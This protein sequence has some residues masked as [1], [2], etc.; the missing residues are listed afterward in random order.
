[1]AEGVRKAPPTAEERWP[2][3][4]AGEV[5]VERAPHVSP[6][7]GDKDAEQNMAGSPWAPRCAWRCYA[8]KPA[9][10]TQVLP[11][12]L[13]RSG[14]VLSPRKMFTAPRQDRRRCLSFQTDRVL[15]SQSLWGMRTGVWG[16]A[17]LLLLSLLG[18]I[19][20]TSAC[21]ILELHVSGIRRHSPATWLSSLSGP[22]HELAEA[23]QASA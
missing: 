10:N 19:R 7:R 20:S 3:G 17:E 15:P 9:Q 12:R 6:R 13:P 23:S 8:S 21:D 11:S 14:M 22:L 5:T 18:S 16:G 1:M 2:P 4:A